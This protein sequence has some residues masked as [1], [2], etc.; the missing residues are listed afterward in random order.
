MSIFTQKAGT[1]QLWMTSDEVTITFTFAPTGTTTRSSTASC[2][3]LP[4]ARA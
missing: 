3:G 2:L 1:P 4:R